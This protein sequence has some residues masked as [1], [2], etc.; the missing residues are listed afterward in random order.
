M[1]IEMSAAGRANVD[2]LAGQSFADDGQ[3][4]EWLG[5]RVTQLAKLEPELKQV[6]ADLRELAAA[7]AAEPLPQGGTRISGKLHGQILKAMGRTAPFKNGAELM[8]ALAVQDRELEQV[9]ARLHAAEMQATGQRLAA[10]RRELE[11]AAEETYPDDFER[12]FGE[13]AQLAIAQRE[14][15]LEGKRLAARRAAPTNEDEEYQRDFERR[16]GQK[17]QG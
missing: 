7:H 4:V 1:S 17:A 12:R 6:H 5:R 3:R 8:E 13:P 10:E 16:F 9:N 11:A 15:E 2:R 14:R